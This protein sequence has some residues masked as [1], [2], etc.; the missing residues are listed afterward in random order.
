MAGKEL[1]L[2]IVVLRETAY[3]VQITLSS[4]IKY[5]DMLNQWYIPPVSGMTVG[6]HSGLSNA[7]GMFEL[8][9]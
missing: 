6:S 2:L 9:S 1:I 7:Q 8:V 5:C 3:Y 4:I